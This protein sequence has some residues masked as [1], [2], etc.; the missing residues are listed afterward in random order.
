MELL[1]PYEMTRLREEARSLNIHVEAVEPDE[2]DL[3][4]MRT[5]QLTASA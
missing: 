2:I 4:V 5:V 3:I 1:E